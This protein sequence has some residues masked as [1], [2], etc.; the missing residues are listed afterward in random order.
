VTNRPIEDWNVSEI[1]DGQGNPE[2]DQYIEGVRSFYDNLI[3]LKD[4][5]RSKKE[6][7]CGAKVSSVP[8][9]CI[10]ILHWNGQIN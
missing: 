1:V 8:L 3:E 4:Q 10:G 2:D 6:A 7:L 9:C 5:P